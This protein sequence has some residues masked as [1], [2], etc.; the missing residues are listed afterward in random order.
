[1]TDIP[2]T[3]SSHRAM[4]YLLLNEIRTRPLDED[5]S[6]RRALETMKSRHHSATSETCVPERLA[7]W[8][9]EAMSEY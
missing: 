6:E 5:R 4:S 7:K 8:Q 1:M 2:T 9:H 3:M